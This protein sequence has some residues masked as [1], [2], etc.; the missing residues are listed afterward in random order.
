MRRMTC[1]SMLIVGALCWMEVPAFALTVN[2]DTGPDMVAGNV[3]ALNVSGTWLYIGG[4]FTAIRNESNV[5]RCRAQ[6][7]VRFNETTGVGDC[8]F[9]PAIPGT[10]VDGLVVMGGFVYVGG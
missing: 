10:Q 5:D 4:K 8:T 7:L 9:T 3:Y 6:N 2:P 1:V